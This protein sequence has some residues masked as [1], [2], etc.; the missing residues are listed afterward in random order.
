VITHILNIAKY[1]ADLI[2]YLRNTSSRGIKK[3]GDF[4]GHF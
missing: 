1:I 2:V 3:R 4:G